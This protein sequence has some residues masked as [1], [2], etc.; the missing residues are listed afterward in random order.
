[1]GGHH[2]TPVKTGTRWGKLIVGK[3]VFKNESSQVQWEVTCDCGTKIRVW[4]YNL[5]KGKTDCGCVPKP[6]KE[7]L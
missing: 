2:R 7:K 1:M 5:V 3:P 4:G 6:R